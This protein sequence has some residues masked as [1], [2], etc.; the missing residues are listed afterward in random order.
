MKK[1]KY[2]KMQPITPIDVKAVII[3]HDSPLKNIKPIMVKIIRIDWP[4]SGCCNKSIIVK[5]VNDTGINWREWFF[6]ILD[7][8]KNHE[9]RII[10][11]GLRNSDGW[12]VNPN[13]D[14]H[15]EA[16][17]LLTPI[18]KVKKIP[19]KLNIKIIN[20]NFLISSEGNIE[21]EIKKNSE[22]KK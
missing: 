21:I 4:T 16:P 14:S 1:F 3:F 20:D 2:K 13:A 22:I 17:P 18:I 5:N 9:T 6:S 10:K 11:D 12:I 15:L 19:I 7:L 8:A